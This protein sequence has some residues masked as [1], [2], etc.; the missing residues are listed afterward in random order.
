[1]SK[2]DKPEVRR[3][4]HPLCA[5]VK[6]LREAYGDT[7]ERF[8]RRLDISITSASRFELGK[9]VPKDAGMLMKLAAAATDKG[10][11]EA[12][13][14]F[15]RAYA[16]ADSRSKMLDTLVRLQTH[17]YYL[18]ETTKSLAHWRYLAALRLAMIE[19]PELQPALDNA[20]APALD[21]VDTALKTVEDPFHV[22][23]NELDFQVGELAKQKQLMKFQNRKK[24]QPK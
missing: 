12:A 2:K 4:L 13:E 22:N 11:T 7:L 15:K 24:E 16:E 14:L 18:F 20:L 1:M 17:E 19:F 3:Q 10:V 5:A 21:I 6:T 23:Y 9:A 8:S